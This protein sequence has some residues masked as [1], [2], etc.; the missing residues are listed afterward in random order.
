MVQSY[1][2]GLP[3]APEL[4]YGVP[5]FKYWKPHPGLPPKWTHRLE[6]TLEI[7]KSNHQ[8][9]LPPSKPHLLLPRPQPPNYLQGRT[10]P[11]QD[12]PFQ[13]MSLGEKNQRNIHLQEPLCMALSPGTG[14]EQ[15]PGQHSSMLEDGCSNA[16]SPCWG[17]CRS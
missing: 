10:T 16:L 15:E 4:T 7:T 17:R 3:W 8:L 5:G 14:W 6:N 9:D 12:N 13:C 11:P 2:A 1:K